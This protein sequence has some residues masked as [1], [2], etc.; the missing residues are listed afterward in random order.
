M[1]AGTTRTIIVAVA[2]LACVGGGLWFAYGPRG[3]A[4]SAAGADELSS[5]EQTARDALN[6]EEWD[7]ARHAFEALLAQRPGHAAAV[8]G[9]ALAIREAANHAAFEALLDAVA[10]QRWGEAHE[11]LRAFPVDSV[12]HERVEA[13]RAEI[14]RNFARVELARARMLL[15]ADRLDDARAAVDA[16]AAHGLVPT[17]TAALDRAIAR[18]AKEARAADDA[19]Q[20]GLAEPKEVEPEEAEPEE[21]EPEEAEPEEADAAPEPESDVAV[22]DRVIQESLTQMARGDR[23]GALD[24]LTRAAELQP[25]SHVPPQRMCALLKAEGRHA[26]ALTACARWLELEPNPAY[27][28]AIERSIEQLEEKL[29]AE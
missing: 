7:Q 21:A 13:L 14:E 5:L 1:M 4:V 19:P 22:F 10:Y 11:G 25:S 8:Q 28:G 9:L 23:A 17:R 6:A 18:A 16:L 27:H 12:Y 24:G 15:K 26:E 3:A 20:P 2:A 29:D